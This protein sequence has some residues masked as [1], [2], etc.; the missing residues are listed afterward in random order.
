VFLKNREKFK[1]RKKERV[2]IGGVLRKIAP[3]ILDTMFFLVIINQWENIPFPIDSWFVG[4]LQPALVRNQQFP[5][6][7]VL[8]ETQNS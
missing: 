5:C 2:S 8:F 4:I 1:I 6:S 3:K 7:L